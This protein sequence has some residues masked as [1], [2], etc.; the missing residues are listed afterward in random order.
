MPKVA[1]GAAIPEYPREEELADD[2]GE[3]NENDKVIKLQRAAKGGQ[4]Q[5]FI[6][7]AVERSVC[8]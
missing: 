7:L 4:R 3:E 8:I 1:P 5:R 6:I 2:G